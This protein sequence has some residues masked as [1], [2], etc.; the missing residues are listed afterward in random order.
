MS[1]LRLF[2]GVLATVLNTIVLSPGPTLVQAELSYY[3]NLTDK[4]NCVST[5]GNIKSCE[6]KG[7]LCGYG[8]LLGVSYCCDAAD[9]ICYAW[10]PGCAG[11][12]GGPDDTQFQCGDGDNGECFTVALFP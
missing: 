10:A 3:L 12:D 9:P 5:S 8:E 11:D 2:T 7:G 4:A 6:P 1:S